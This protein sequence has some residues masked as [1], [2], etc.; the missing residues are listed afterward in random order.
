MFNFPF[1]STYPRTYLSGSGCLYANEGTAAGLDLNQ[2]WRIHTG[3]EL[4]MITRVSLLF[5]LKPDVASSCDR[6]PHVPHLV[7][8]SRIKKLKK[9]ITA[10][11]SALSSKQRS[12]KWGAL[13]TKQLLQF[14]FFYFTGFIFFY[15]TG[16]PGVLMFHSKHVAA[17]VDTARVTTFVKSLEH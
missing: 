10:V 8:A 1:R 14:H 5:V 4:F 3:P 15:I 7:T 11:T 17:A 16:K 13:K 2:R 12:T 9:H 6:Q